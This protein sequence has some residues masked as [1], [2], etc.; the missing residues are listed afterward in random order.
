MQLPLV[1]YALRPGVDYWAKRNALYTAITRAKK[2]L[3]M[4]GDVDTYVRVALQ[5]GNR[6]KTRL[7]WAL[8]DALENALFFSY[9]F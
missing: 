9:D 8:S 3:V 6:R 2:Y 5:E 1:L 4:Y 7:Q